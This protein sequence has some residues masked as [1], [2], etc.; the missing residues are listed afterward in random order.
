[1]R[2]KFDANQDFQTRAID[3]V[4]RLFDGQ[5]PVERELTFALGS[6]FGAVANVLDLGEAQLSENLRRVQAEVG[7]R[8]SSGL[9]Y[10]EDNIET[11]RGPRRVRF[12]NYSVEMETG[13]GKTYVYIR[14]AL[15][16]SRHY[17]MRKFIIVVPSVAIREGVLT[18]LRITESHLRSLFGNVAYTYHVYDSENLS[19]VRQFALSDAI[20]L[21]V[22][23]ID[24]FN[25]ASNVIRQSTD[26]LQGETPIHLIQAARPIL[27]LDEPQNMESELRVKALAALDP[28]FALRYSATHRNPYSLVYRLSPY[29]AYR[30]RL[31]KRIE[32]ASVLKEGDRSSPYMLL[33]GIDAEKKRITARI[34][35][36]RLLKTGAVKEQVVAVGPG[37]D[38]AEIADR[39]EYDGYVVEEID[40]RRKVVR[41]ANDVELGVGD[42]RGADREAIFDAQIRQTIEEHFRKQRRMRAAGIKVLSL[43]FI[44]RVA[45]YTA[46]EG[47]IRL[48]FDKAF[49]DIKTRFHEWRKVEAKN[50][51]AAYFAEKKR[52]SGEVEAIDSKSGEDVEDERAYDLIMRAKEQL[53]SLD[54]PVAFLF[55]HSALREGWDNPN[56]FQICTL[57]QTASEMKK[58][59]EV[60]RGIRLAVNQD[61]E[62]VHDEQVNVLTVV[63]NES[64][65]DYVSRLQSETEEE[66][67]KDGVPPPPANARKRRTVRLRKEFFARPEFAELWE[68]IRHRTRYTVTFDCEALLAEV[69]PA[70]D[71]VEVKPPRVTVTKAEVDVSE[72]DEFTPQVIGTREVQSLAGRA[73]LPNLIEVMAHLME[74]TTPRMRLTRSTLLEVFRR[75]KDKSAV[76]SNPQEFARQAVRILK[77]ALREHLVR[78]IRYAKSGDWFDM[79]QLDAEFS[80]W[81][82]NSVPAARSLYDHVVCESGVESAFVAGLEGNKQVTLYVK[83]PEWFVVETPLGDYNP[84]WALVMQPRDTSGDD[85]GPTLYLVRETK[86]E[87]WSRA[88]RSDEHRKVDCG[89]KHFKD[90]LGV[91]FKVVSK[92]SDLP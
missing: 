57:N 68:R 61:G 27:I 85:S 62:R 46:E 16:L 10:I 88:G 30:Q 41:F 14:T 80:T 92:A 33:V 44:D 51:R 53:L 26:R 60:G 65:E 90:A 58:R 31:V 82:E 70:V 66:Y 20:E 81:E 13:T 87:A 15:E 74:H 22:M 69:M 43:F 19:H 77:S 40:K 48:A 75:A 78:G 18:T 73:P 56:V 9:A 8:G 36:H 25:K 6:G 28:L 38:L 76:L 39:P 54:E 72:K 79:A 29:E 49:D 17:G 89:A 50:V 63:A 11:V 64:Y 59:Q 35:I 34:A 24:S 55:S 3:A 91:D 12:P 86:D 45:N 7:V 71:A 67:G 42:A 21:M 4:V 37:E 52:K 47:V 23:T 2:L 84:D 1:M 83:L 5:P 32:V